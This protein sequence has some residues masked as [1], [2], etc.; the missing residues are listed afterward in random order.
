MAAR[1]A[2]QAHPD[3]PGRAVTFDGFVHIFRTTRVEAARGGQKGG[4]TKLI[5][6][7]ATASRSIAAEKETI[8][9][10][11]DLRNGSIEGFAAGIDDDGP[12]GIQPIEGQA[13]RLTDAPAD[14]IPHDGFTD[15]AGEGEA[16]MR[17]IG[18]RFTETERSEERA[19][20]PAPL[21]VDAVENLWNAAGG[22]VSENQVWRPT[23]QN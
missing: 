10:A 9:F 20:K 5:Y 1:E 17:A 22:H 13:D 14:T 12:L 15:C 19:G 21:I 6:A 18:L 2:A 16:D 4:D 11:P 7:E 3:T 8:H 23:S